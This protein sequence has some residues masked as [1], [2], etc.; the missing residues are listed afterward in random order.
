MYVNISHD[1]FSVYRQRGYEFGS[2]DVIV[3]RIRRGSHNFYMFGIYRNPDLSDKIFDCLLTAVAKVQSVDIK[4]SFLFVGD[5]NAHHEEW[6]RSPTTNLSGRAG[7]DFASL[8]G[9]D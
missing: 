5:A 9:Y 6:L 8:S 3:V 4:A 1:D 7:G 2:C